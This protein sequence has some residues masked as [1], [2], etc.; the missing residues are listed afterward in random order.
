VIQLAKEGAGDEHIN[1]ALSQIDAV[2]NELD[3]A[4]YAI[5]GLFYLS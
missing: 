1:D 2:K 4:S 3:T 5:D